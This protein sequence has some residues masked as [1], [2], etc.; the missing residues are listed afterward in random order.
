[1]YNKM[2][3]KVGLQALS[4]SLGQ[5]CHIVYN[6]VLTVVSAKCGQYIK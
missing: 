1:M 4:D 2:H 3:I 6:M 5:E